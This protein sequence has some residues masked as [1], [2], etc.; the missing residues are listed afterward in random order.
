MRKIGLQIEIKVTDI[1]NKIIEMLR[2]A[3]LTKSTIISS[4]IHNELLNIKKLQPH[5]KLGALLSERISD[6]RDLKKAFKRVIKKNIFAIHPHFAVV[7]KELIDIA[8]NNNLKVNVWTVNERSDMERLIKL[9]VD[10]LITDDIPLAKEL[11][12]R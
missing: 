1:G 6:P 11:L 9:G 7:D 4:F 8:H 3:D 2:E 5:I 12:G 10:G